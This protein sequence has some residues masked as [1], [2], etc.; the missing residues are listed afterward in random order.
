VRGICGWGRDWFAAVACWSPYP[1]I[2]SKN[3]CPA[4]LFLGFKSSV[5]LGIFGGSVCYLSLENL[6]LCVWSV[7]LCIHYELI[8]LC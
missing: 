1:S 6:L 5:N 4:P 8:V 2:F 7:P 3:I